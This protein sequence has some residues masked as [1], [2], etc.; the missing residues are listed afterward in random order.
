MTRK[1]TGKTA[2]CGVLGALAVVLL[3]VG[4][5]LPAATF[6][7]PALSGLV[8]M[9]AAAE[10]GVTLG[11]TL[12]VAVA[13]LALFL[14]PDK[15]MALMFAGLLGYYPLL[16]APLEKLHPRPVRGLAKALVFNGALALVYGLLLKI[17]PVAA[18][19]Q[20]MGGAGQ[21]F[22]AVLLILGNITFW[23]YD[24]A[25]LRVMQLYRYKLRPKLKK[26]H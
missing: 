13:L 1:Q 7:A 12:Y 21:G 22:L 26:L 3:L 14:A 20:E 25:L 2:L 11:W 23:V 9:V 8:V 24:L 15:E 10:C 6:C 5:I 4:G 16:K 18:L 19:E 17:F